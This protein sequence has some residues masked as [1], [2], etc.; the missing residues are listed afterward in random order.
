MQKGI[1]IEPLIKLADDGL[2]LAQAYV[3]CHYSLKKN[4]QSAIIYADMALQQNE[5]IGFYIRGV[6]EKDK[7]R[8]IYFFKKAA[9]QG[10]Y[11]S[12]NYLGENQLRPNE[13]L[14]K[15]SFHSYGAY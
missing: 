8:K 5:R 15:F 11:Y 9:D 6:C 1:P 4:T 14:F 13:N 12:K 3:A 2:P 7:D 10:C